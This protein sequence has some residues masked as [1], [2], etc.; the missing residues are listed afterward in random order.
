MTHDK[1]SKRGPGES[2]AL[3]WEVEQLSFV[4]DDAKNLSNAPLGLAHLKRDT[5]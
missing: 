5:G 4:D 1:T 3:E 2:R